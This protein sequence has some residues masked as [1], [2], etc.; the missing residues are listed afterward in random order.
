[1]TK[2]KKHSI[3][4]KEGG[5]TPWNRPITRRDFVK[6]GIAAGGVAGAAVVVGGKGGLQALQVGTPPVT[7]TP[8]DPFAARLITLNVNGTNSQVQV[9]P[10]SMLVDVLR[11][12]MGLIAVKRSCNRMSCGGCTV[13]ID[14]QAYE[15]CT[16]LALRAVGHS[17]VTPEIATKDPVVDALQKA[18]PIADMAQCGY[19]SPG[20][21]MAATP[22]LR[23]NQNPTVND[24]KA[25]LSG[26][27]CRCGNYLHIIDTVM[28]AAKTLRGGS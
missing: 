28:L 20:I 21:I 2:G 5:E 1:M 6:T 7:T 24:I 19:C 13:L 17:I 26:N 23:Q 27:I 16:Y 4:P 9:E 15:A 12:T 14:G 18:A 10:R 11:D 25:A 8:T 3:S 22:L